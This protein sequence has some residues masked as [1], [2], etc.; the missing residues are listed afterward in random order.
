MTRPPWPSPPST[1]RSGS[2]R[3]ELARI[4][5]GHYAPFLDGHEQAV[6][7]ELAFLNRHLLETA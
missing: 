1:P 4:P 5:G 2:P 7:A 3:G 6:K